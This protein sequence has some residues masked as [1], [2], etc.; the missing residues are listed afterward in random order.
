MQNCVN[1]EG[2]FLEEVPWFDTTKQ[3]QAKLGPLV[4][5]Y[6]KPVSLLQA[7]NPEAFKFRNLTQNT[8]TV[9]I[10]SH[11]ITLHCFQSDNITSRQ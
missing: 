9:T 10:N 7:T 6:D 11:R 8:T 2:Y 5:C 1:F 4:G 3:V